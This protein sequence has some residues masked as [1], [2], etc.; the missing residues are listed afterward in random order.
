M[1]IVDFAEMLETSG[2]IVQ[3]H[4]FKKGQAPNPPYLVYTLMRPTLFFADNTLTYQMKVVR[5]EL[6]TEQK[7]LTLEEKVEGL[8]S[9]HKLF[10]E[11]EEELVIE[12]EELFVKSYLVFLY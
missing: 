5:V 6:V 9:E 3:Y 11:M 12:T 8:F 10:F 2:L 7:D 1:K 4:A